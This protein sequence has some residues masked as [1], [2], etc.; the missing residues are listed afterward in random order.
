MNHPLHAKPLCHAEDLGEPIPDSPHA[1]SVCLPSWA[2]V[3][4]YE[5]KEPRVITRMQTG[6][7]RF[8]FHPLVEKVRTRLREDHGTEGSDLLP[9]PDEEA[10][11]ECAAFT[12]KGARGIHGG[13]GLWASVFPRESFP[14]AFSY[15][16]HAGRILS[17]RAAGDWL[18]DG[19]LRAADSLLETKIKERLSG[20][21]GAP[22]DMVSLHPS[23]MAAIFAA[24]QA[25]TVRRPGQRT[26]MFGFPYTDTLK[27]LEK[28]GSGVEFFPR[29]DADDLDAL[30][31]L[32]RN[33]PVAAVFCEFPSNPKLVVPDLPSIH[34]AASAA[35]VPVVVDDTIGTFFNVD[36]LPYADLVA[37][38]LTKAVSG[39]GDV[40]AGCL[41]ANPRGLFG[42]G[43]PAAGGGGIYEADLS[44]LETNSR[45]FPGRMKAGNEAALE[46][47]R[48]LAAHPAVEKVCY[49]GLGTSPVY[50]ALRKPDGG[51][52]GLLS[53]IPRD[54]A[55]NSPRIYEKIALNRGISLGTSYTLVCP[56]VQLAHY[57][58][59]DWAR[60]CG[61]DP[62]LLRVAVG[63]EPDLIARFA[64]ALE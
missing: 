26:V 42:S 30:A 47:A 60:R 14:R 35:G 54:A 40:M 16:Q 32:L 8:F 51:Y 58:E 49:P 31:D 33:E 27:I 38:S 29:G 4:G 56:Y 6:Y 61:I 11:R 39:E 41:T 59:L 37:T 3:I 48:F 44:V 25:V 46:L 15:W 12:G 24:F 52:G 20:W 36:V 2:D 7:P 5:E 28:F 17:S 18:R 23:G 21:S 63:T 64:A 22:A 9:F 55:T 1:V 45:D 34:A 13:G 10:A 50:E 57:R 43:V 19:K 53:F 62:F